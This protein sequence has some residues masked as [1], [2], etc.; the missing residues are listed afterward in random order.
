MSY[1][2]AVKSFREMFEGLRKP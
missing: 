1:D 2:F